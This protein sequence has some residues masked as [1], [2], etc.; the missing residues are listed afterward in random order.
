[1]YIS[2]TE[3]GAFGSSSGRLRLRLPNTYIY[4]DTTKQSVYE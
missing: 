2:A 1:M 4:S 3:K